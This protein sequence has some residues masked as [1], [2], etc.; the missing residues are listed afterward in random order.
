[1]FEGWRGVDPVFY[2]SCHFPDNK[3]STSY[4]FSE[5]SVNFLKNQDGKTFKMRVLFTNE[6]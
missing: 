3:V 1:M 4:Q 5:N 2:N 6:F